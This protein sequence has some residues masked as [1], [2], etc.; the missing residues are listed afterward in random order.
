MTDVDL[1]R[2]RVP[3]PRRADGAR[4][5]DAI[6]NAAREVFLADG[7][8]VP[9]ETVAERAGVGIATLYRSFPTREALLVHL[10]VGEIDAVLGDAAD[11]EG[12]EPW[13]A[14]TVWTRRFVERLGT[15]RRLGAAVTPGTDVYEACSA[16]ILGAAMPIVD[17]ARAGGR[18]RPDVTD[19]DL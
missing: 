1:E 16:A 2:F 12:L 10:Y 9:L 11:V 14:M 17:R 7:T 5:F 15:K 4:N 18:L 19:L 6:V 13:E 3:R 8:D